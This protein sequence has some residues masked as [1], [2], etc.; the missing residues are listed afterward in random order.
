AFQRDELPELPWPPPPHAR[1]ADSGFTAIRRSD[2]ALEMSELRWESWAVMLGL[3]IGLLFI[4]V[5]GPY[6]M[7]AFT[8]IAQPLLALASLSWA[9]KVVG[10]VRS[11]RGL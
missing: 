8:F 1:C 4:L 10:D 11:R 9:V 3:L 2:E 7:G 5:P 6:E